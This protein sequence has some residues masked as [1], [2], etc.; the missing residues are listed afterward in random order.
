M[1]LNPDTVADTWIQLA[2][3]AG[4]AAKATVPAK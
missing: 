3:A 1:S 4:A 2:R